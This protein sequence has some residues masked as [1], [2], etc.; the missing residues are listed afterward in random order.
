MTGLLSRER[1]RA[2]PGYNRWLVPPAALAIHLC[3]GQ[4]YA[5]SVFNLPLSRAI[6]IT[7]S[8][9]G[10]WTLSDLGW[11][12]T[13]AIVFLGLS[14]AVGGRW[15]ERVGPRTSG[16]VSALCWGS[17]F[18]LSAAGVY[19]HQI[20]LLY[21]GYGVIGGCGLG[22]GYITPVSTLIHWFPDRRGMA[23]G[24][25]IM[26]F[27]GGAML[28]SPLSEILMRRFASP[29][30]VGVAETFLVLGAVYCAAMFAGAFGFRLPPPGWK[31]AGW[32]RPKQDG[33]MRA[34]FFVNPTDALL[35]PSFYFLWAVLFLNVTAGIGVL[36]QASAMSQEMFPSTITATAASGFVGLL[37]LFNLC[38]RFVWSSASDRLGRKRTYAIFFAFGTLLYALVPQTGRM[39][40]VALFV[41]CFAV[42]MSMYGGGFATIPAYL[43]DVFGTRY[44]GAIHGRLLTAWSAAGV[45]GPVLVNYIREYQSR[46]GVAKA[47]A[48]NITMYL[49][50][51]L[52][53]VGF[54]CNLAVTKVSD[55]LAQD[56][57]APAPVAKEKAATA[58]G[59]E[60][61]TNLWLLVAAA[62][63]AVLLP[64]LWGVSMTFDRALLLFR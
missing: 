41:A 10:D 1:I 31:P 40:S 60:G 27:G 7:E 53:V 57:T 43:S 64:M 11:V 2:K 6:G 45:A 5:F 16:V 4:V 25:A 63:A 12:F 39:G 30:S 36:G 37:S 50:A 49:M 22:L 52:L 35:T 9:E 38:G 20:W 24:M 33:P 15:L 54:F 3:I 51:S 29:T 8:V 23:T 48:Y 34:H 55:R 56:D 14:A 58:D 42:I 62:W 61:T 19:R 44:V 17:G 21:L 13:L 18:L 26:G 59:S 46:H 47:D 32:T 28:A